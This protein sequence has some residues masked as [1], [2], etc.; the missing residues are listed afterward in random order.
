VAQVV[1]HQDE[2]DSQWMRSVQLRA[3]VNVSTKGLRRVAR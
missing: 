2:Y 1:E 3:K